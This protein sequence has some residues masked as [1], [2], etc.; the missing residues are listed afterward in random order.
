MALQCLDLAES[1][2]SWWNVP[3]ATPVCEYMEMVRWNESGGHKVLFLIQPA[4]LDSSSFPGKRK[5]LEDQSGC[6]QRVNN[7]LHH[8]GLAMISFLKFPAA[9][10]CYSWLH[11]FIGDYL[12]VV[13]ANLFCEGYR[14]CLP[15]VA[16][17]AL[18]L[19]LWKWKLWITLR[20]S[21]CYTNYKPYMFQGD[22]I[23]TV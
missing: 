6:S 9:F 17:G 18:K 2:P 1:S 19:R 3:M 11:L 16:L 20:I 15:T 22:E 7:S 8:A 12:S 13:A 23:G 4:S 5:P 10:H 14:L 21:N